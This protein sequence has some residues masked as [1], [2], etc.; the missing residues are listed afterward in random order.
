MQL[1][2]QTRNSSIELLR[3]LCITI[4]ILLHLVEHNHCCD[5]LFGS[6]LS[7]IGNCGVTTFVLISGY[8]GVSCDYRKLFR[9]RNITSFYLLVALIIEL[10][11]GSPVSGNNIFSVVFPII[12]GKYWFLT[13][14]VLL[15]IFSPYINRLLE[16]LPTTKLRLLAITL[17]VVLYV[18]PT[19]FFH[20]LAGDGKNIVYMTA[21][22]IIGR[23]IAREKLEEKVN[24]LSLT[25][26]FFVSIA[27]IVVFDYLKRSMGVT[28]YLLASHL[29]YK[30]DADSSL[31]ILLASASLFL[32][33]THRIFHN[34]AINQMAKSVFA[35][36]VLE[37]FVRPF[38]F[39]FLNLSNLNAYLQF[40][41]VIGF[42]VAVFLL[43]CGIDQLRIL[44][45]S[46]IA[47]RFE[48]V[49][50]RALGKAKDLIGKY[51]PGIE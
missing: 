42:S 18:V 7:A 38:L 31:F 12:S 33:F 20:Y 1:M 29:M 36:Y 16:S 39:Q 19:F 17:V 9:L 15:L 11:V 25:I 35:V 41:A 44:A 10:V 47:D 23:Y 13:S 14:Y 51:I 34:N 4:I 24:Q 28:D 2:A 45:T 43:C 21:V 6:I 22:Y 37:W 5:N 32:S 27:V 30:L 40:F 26:T 8:F 48:T 3:I 50:M 49:E 46:K